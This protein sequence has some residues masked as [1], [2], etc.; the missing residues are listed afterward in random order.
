[1]EKPPHLEWKEKAATTITLNTNHYEAKQ[2]KGQGPKN[3][4][5]LKLSI[6]SLRLE[7]EDLLFQCHQPERLMNNCLL[8]WWS[9][10][11]SRPCRGE[12]GPV[13]A[14]EAWFR[15]KTQANIWSMFI[16]HLPGIWTSHPEGDN[17]KGK[18]SNR[19]DESEFEEK[20]WQWKVWTVSTPSLPSLL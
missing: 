17:L 3:I 5:K 16:T 18:G 10:A 4:G 19:P 6:C 14:E 2:Y 8:R 11:I 1:V 15:R 9:A 12:R 7:L 20:V 13:G